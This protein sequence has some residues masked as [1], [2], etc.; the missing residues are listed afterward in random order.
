MRQVSLAP[1]METTCH[2]LRPGVPA[3]QIRPRANQNLSPVDSRP[4]AWDGRPS[5]L[6]SGRAL[7]V[8]DAR[9]GGRMFAPPHGMCSY[10]GMVVQFVG[11]GLRNCCWSSKDA[12]PEEV[13]CLP[14]LPAQLETHPAAMEADGWPQ[15]ETSDTLKRC[16]SPLVCSARVRCTAQ[17]HLIHQPRCPIQF[18]WNLKLAV[19]AAAC[20]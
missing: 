13:S 14:P 15:A 19:G 3:Q 2:R 11:P 5:G 10:R 16:W 4:L 12:G 1:E 20:R 18:Q 6:G 8:R 9:H 17:S 7:A